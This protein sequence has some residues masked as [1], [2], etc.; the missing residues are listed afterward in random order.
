MGQGRAR[1]HQKQR[2]GGRADHRFGTPAIRGHWLKAPR[3]S[4]H[5][6]LLLIPTSSSEV[7]ERGEK[8]TT[9][10][11][12]RERREE[13][14]IIP[15]GHGQKWLLLAPHFLNRAS[16]LW[17][18]A[19]CSAIALQPFVR[20]AAEDGQPATP[21]RPTHYATL[22]TR[23]PVR[24]ASEL[25][26]AARMVYLALLLRCC[27]PTQLALACL[28]VT[29]EA[30]CNRQASAKKLSS[31]VESNAACFPHDHPDKSERF[32][33]PEQWSLGTTRCCCGGRCYPTLRPPCPLSSPP[34]APSP[35]QRSGGC[36]LSLLTVTRVCPLG[37]VYSRKMDECRTSFGEWLR[38]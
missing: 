37:I 15:V 8:R 24:C 10:P 5:F 36:C 9:T 13:K 32:K 19:E 29:V 27:L 7:E 26:A 22:R 6:F 1:T 11:S 16:S 33:S 4:L 17:C 3:K 25:I 14:P 2:R 21:R 38:Y 31:D 34:R 35:L 20:P 12:R 30:D 28:L 23:A 18:V